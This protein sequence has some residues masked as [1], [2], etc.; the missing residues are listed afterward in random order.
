MERER[1]G[2]AEGGVAAGGLAIYGQ[3]AKRRKE[4]QEGENSKKLRGF[5]CGELLP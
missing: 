2:E 1:E 4:Q 5:E 3:R